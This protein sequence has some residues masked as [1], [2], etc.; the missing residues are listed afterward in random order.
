MRII[1]GTH[2]GKRIQAPKQLSAR[3]TTDM[4]KEALFNILNNHYF[5][6]ELKVL[7]LYSGTGNISFEF[8]SRGTP[9][10][11]AV[12]QDPKSAGFIS[13]T[14]AELGFP[15]ITIKSDA[16]KY[17]SKT[18]ETFDIIF[19]DPPYRQT[20]KEFM[21]IP[22]VVFERK[23]LRDG[24]TLIIEHSKHTDLTPLEFHNESRKYGGSVFSFFSEPE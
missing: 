13:K 4:A 18:D 17:L 11:I 23:L 22:K 5:L 12:D 24:G 21:L 7:D 2:K 20:V 8:A 15:I 10:I 14:A 16:R 9:E 6:N 19:A 1:S 3:P